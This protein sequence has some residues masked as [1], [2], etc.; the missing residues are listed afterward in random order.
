MFVENSE[1]KNNDYKLFTLDKVKKGKTISIVNLPEGLLKIQLIR[2]GV[3]EGAEVNCLE[4]LPGGTVVLQKNRQE[5]AIGYDLAKK[6]EVL[7]I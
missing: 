2:L 6:I 4:R 5:I 7:Y 1:S 3:T